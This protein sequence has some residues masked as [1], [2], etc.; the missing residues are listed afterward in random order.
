MEQQE[1]QELVE[2]LEQA[3]NIKEENTMRKLILLFTIFA[4]MFTPIVYS[5]VRDITNAAE[6]DAESWSISATTDS[7]EITVSSL[8]IPSATLDGITFWVTGDTATAR[9]RHLDGTYSTDGRLLPGYSYTT[10]SNTLIDKVTIL[11]FTEDLGGAD[12]DIEASAFMEGR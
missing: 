3:D 11:Y 10:P 7:I 12:A 9:F 6:V 5:S 2:Q 1:Q 8:R 4:L